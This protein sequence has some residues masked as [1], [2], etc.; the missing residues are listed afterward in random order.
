[1][2]ASFARVGAL[3]YVVQRQDGQW[4]WL[5]R[6][7]GDERQLGVLAVRM[8]PDHFMELTDLCLA[9]EIDIHIDR[10]FTLEQTADALAYVGE[11]KALGKVVVSV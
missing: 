5:D 10:T 9:G 4:A 1:M 6:K 7:T 8:G 2:I 11:G 3:D